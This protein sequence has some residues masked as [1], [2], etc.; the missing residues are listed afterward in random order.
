MSCERLYDFIAETSP[1][2]F[3]KG[4]KFRAIPFLNFVCVAAAR[5]R[6]PWNDRR[7]VFKRLAS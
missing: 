4:V 6:K 1:G 3:A 7:D 5:K 2:E